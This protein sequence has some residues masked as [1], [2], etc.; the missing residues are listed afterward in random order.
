MNRKFFAGLV[1]LF[2]FTGCSA[3][4]SLEVKELKYG[5]AP[6]VIEQSF[7]SKAMKKGDT[8]RMYLRASDPDGDMKTIIAYFERGAGG[9]TTAVSHT[10]IKENDRQ[11]I[12]GNLYWYPG[13]DSY[14][15]PEMVMTIQIQDMAGHFSKPVSLPLRIQLSGSQELPPEGAFQEKE[16]GP[17]MITLRPVS[18][19]AG[20]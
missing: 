14:A 9:G 13:P 19:N 15:V 16:L 1:A 6:P 17:V 18:A 20:P 4:E 8:W 5:K 2:L 7:A 3:C 12:S 11:E 10:R